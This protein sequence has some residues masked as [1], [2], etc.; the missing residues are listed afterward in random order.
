M[1]ADH[2]AGCLRLQWYPV[3]PYDDNNSDYCL[4][5]YH[6]VTYGDSLAA[7]V[8]EIIAREIIAPY[9]ALALAQELLQN[10][11]YVDDVLS[12][13]D[14]KKALWAA[15]GEVS[16]TMFKYDFHVK[17]VFTNLL[18]HLDEPDQLLPA[19]YLED[20]E[21]VFHHAWSFKVDMVNI[22]PLFNTHSKKRGKYDGPDLQVMDLSTLKLTRRVMSRILGHG[23]DPSGCFLN[24]LVA[25]LKVLFFR[26]CIVT[27]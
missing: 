8:L 22:A 5:F 1:R 18:W 21:T 25:S 4:I 23:Y 13:E 3:D 26:V 27:M 11:R 7:L 2:T 15:M 16:R 17:K 20:M 9:C 10:D 12:S 14:D 6:V 19:E 24:V